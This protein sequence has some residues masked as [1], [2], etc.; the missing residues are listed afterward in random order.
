MLFYLFFQKLQN[1]I[2]LIL[3][4][5]ELYFYLYQLKILDENNQILYFSL[6]YLANLL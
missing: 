2:Y 1:L 5:T 6:K 3:M 4:L